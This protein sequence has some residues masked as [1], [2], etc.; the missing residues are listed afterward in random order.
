MEL[1]WTDW[2]SIIAF[3]VVAL[4]IGVWVTKR[5]GKD[6]SEFFLS[7]RHMPWW[8]L[9]F[10]MVATTFSTD[11]PNLVTNIVRQSGVSGNWCWWA[12]LLTGMLTVF[13]YA[14]LWRRTG[15]MTDIEFYEK[16]YSGKSAAFLRGFRA[17]YLGVFFNCAIMGMVS[18]AAIKIGAVMFQFTAIQTL[19]VAAV[20]TTVFSTL[21]GFRG[22]ILTDFL[23]FIIAMF[24]AV[25]AAVVALGHPAVGGLSGLLSHPNVAD[26]LSFFPDA[27]SATFIT[28]LIIPLTIQ[29][30]ATWYPGAE[31][32]GG[33]YI[34]QRMLAAKDEKHAIGATLFFNCTHYAL[35]PWP[36][37]VV[38]LC[39]LIVFPDLASL[40]EKFPHA[41]KVIGHDLAYPAMLTFLPHGLLGIVLASL[42]AA[43]MSTISTHLNW[44]SSYI[45]NDFY[46]RFVNPEASDK[47][48]V[49]VGR[50]ATVGLMIGMALIAL[51]L[52]SAKQAF[53]ILLL[54]GAG[55][56]LIYILRWFWWRINAWS[57]ISA[58]IISFLVAVTL[59]VIVPYVMGAEAFDAT[60]VGKY[61][62]PIGV[63]ITTVGWL[64]V[65]FL[66]RPTSTEKLREFYALAKPGGPGWRKIVEGAAADGQVLE[67]A[68]AQW[69]VPLAVLCMLAACTAV[70]ATLF[71][72][73]YF[74]YGRITGAVI[75]TVI[76]AASGFFVFKIFRQVA[77]S[78]AEDGEGVSATVGTADSNG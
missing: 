26:K 34:A 2:I 19:L 76:A 63:G 45:V 25:A 53:D 30:W 69:T 28:V 42:I 39:S 49:M 55:T 10:S 41:S 57:E 68:G 64:V 8:L 58:M 61:S 71:A 44:G 9:G 60:F 62:L 24:G 5:A 37:I 3:F 72:T 27:S 18:L 56:G 33:G 38:A 47:A 13:V 75:L 51:G 23:L 7:G 50:I 78:E 20:V 74:L 46:K 54:V 16:R 48:Q 70:Y 52:R 66:T 35:R 1:L 4:A 32:G 73:G 65:T 12:F 43:Y 67:P 36:W 77:S 22:V 59:K 11:T 21:G 15:V 17:L 31:P 29:W 6:S 14:K 40:T